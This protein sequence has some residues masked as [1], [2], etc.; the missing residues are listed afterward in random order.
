[1]DFL[2]FLREFFVNERSTTFPLLHSIKYEVMEMTFHI[3]GGDLRQR[4][5]EAYIKS[6]GF[7]VTSS[8]LGSTAP[9]DWQ[10]DLLILPLPVTRDQKTLNTPL[11][12]E[13]ISLETIAERFQGK[14]VF[15]GILPPFEKAPFK[16]Y[17]Y[18]TAEE[19]T[20]ANAVPT[21]EGALALAIANTSFTLWRQP[22]LVLGGGRIGQLLALRLTAL[23][24]R[25]TV[26]AR[27]SETL[28]L[29]RNLG[30]EGRFF[31]DVPYHRFRLIFNTV[32]APVLGEE[33]FKQ[34]APDTLLMELASAPFGFDPALAVS[35]GVSV[36]N[37][38]GL[39]GKYAPETAA[40][41]IGD[42]ILKEMEHLA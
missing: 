6:K 14:G 31:E 24:A 38:Q 34:F 22:V 3:M 11:S 30:A 42:Y 35:H 16:T 9:P 18:F 32:P 8:F 27:R 2:P 17:D 7:E 28:A 40:A 19:V 15:G 10:A 37:G 12:K 33:Q 29:C 39:P 21:V 4:Y 26:A 23:G 13:R 41:I 1:M 5:L 20:L 36:L 25:V